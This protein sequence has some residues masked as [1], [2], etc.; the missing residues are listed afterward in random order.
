MSR[1]WPSVLHGITGMTFQQT[2]DMNSV[3]CYQLPYLDRLSHKLSHQA[4]RY[5]FSLQDSSIDIRDRP[6]VIYVGRRKIDY[7]FEFMHKQ[8]DLYKLYFECVILSYS[9]SNCCVLVNRDSPWRFNIFDQSLSISFWSV[10]FILILLRY[11][12]CSCFVK[13]QWFLPV[14]WYW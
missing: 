5:A 12:R 8:K 10:S 14:T 4:K 9:M 3:Q 1:L 11:Q 2:T 13:P 6:L 7:D